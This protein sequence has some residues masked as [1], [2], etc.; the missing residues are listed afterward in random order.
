MKAKYVCPKCEE[1]GVF[2]WRCKVCGSC[3]ACCDNVRGVMAC[4]GYWDRKQK[5]AK[6]MAEYE[7]EYE[8]E[9]GHTQEYRDA[10]EQD[11]RDAAEEANNHIDVW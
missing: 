7:K 5:H 6:L 11:A 3:H 2:I 4:K 10:R 9:F 1:S 8:A